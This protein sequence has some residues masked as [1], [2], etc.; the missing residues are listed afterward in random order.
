MIVEYI[1]YFY[2]CNPQNQNEVSGI[3][4]YYPCS[5]DEK[6][7]LKLPSALMKSLPKE[8]EGRFVINKGFEKCLMLYPENEWKKIDARLSKVNTFVTKNRD[9]VRF[10]KSFVTTLIPDAT[11]RVL[12]SKVLIELAEIKKDVVL[13]PMQDGWEI[14]DERTYLDYIK[15]KNSDDFAGLAE[16]VMGGYHE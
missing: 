7:R 10:F 2:V 4:G 9:F 12:I 14:W 5:I 8:A 6:G 1:P 13:V 16:E 3:I 15:T 11:D